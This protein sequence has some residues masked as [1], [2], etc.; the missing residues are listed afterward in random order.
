MSRKQIRAT[1]I[2]F[3]ALILFLVPS[4]ARVQKEAA[5]DYG[6][7]TRTAVPTATPTATAEPSPTPTPSAT[8]TPGTYELLRKKDAGTKKEA[9][10]RLQTRLRELGFFTGEVDG[11]FGDETFNALVSF[12]RVN[13]LSGDGIAGQETQSLLFES[14]NVLDATG[15]RYLDANSLAI[16]PRPTATPTPAPSVLPM[17]DFSYGSRPLSDYFVTGGYFDKSIR[18]ELESLPLNDAL[19]TRALVDIADASQLRS[20]LAGSV[21]APASAALADIADF[22]R[23]VLALAGDNYP[24]VTRGFEARQGFI[25]SSLNENAN[26]LLIIDQAGD[27]RIYTAIGKESGLARDGENVYLAYSGGNALLIN[28]ILQPDLDAIS[29]HRLTAIGQISDKR[30]LVVS[31]CPGQSRPGLTEAELAEYMRESGCQQ[32]YLMTIGDASGLYYAG[33]MLSDGNSSPRRVS[34]ILYFASAQAE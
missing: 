16:T 14:A 12:Q 18:V 28:G 19:L 13:G 22:H 23:A 34:D 10:S 2:V 1:L 26:D 29:P 25:L 9:V 8:P 33:G 15:R 31:A 5:V 17:D 3:L 20:A 4:G 30:Y 7:S 21:E 24:A 6:P 32:A 11:Y 27:L